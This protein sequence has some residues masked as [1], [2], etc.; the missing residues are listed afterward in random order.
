M[1]DVS[2]AAAEV[3]QRQ[4]A[5]GS[6]IRRSSADDAVGKLE[7]GNEEATTTAGGSSS[8]TGVVP[9]EAEED[10][11]A[12]LLARGALTARSVRTSRSVLNVS[13]SAGIP[14]L[15]FAG[16]CQIQACHQRRPRARAETCWNRNS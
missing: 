13:V 1:G 11:E 6:G 8:S 14:I 2:G 16:V 9:A 4:Q 10:G 3:L 12:F 7:A 15:S 5:G